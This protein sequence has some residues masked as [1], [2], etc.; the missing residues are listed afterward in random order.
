MLFYKQILWHDLASKNFFCV[1]VLKFVTFCKAALKFDKKNGRNVNPSSY[2]YYEWTSPNTEMDDT[3]LKTKH[4]NVKIHNK[5]M[6]YA[7]HYT[8]WKQFLNSNLVV[9]SINSE[10]LDPSL[11]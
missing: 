10:S 3:M 6:H 11:M 1:D 9:K 5:M 4:D 8:K 7:W 2:N